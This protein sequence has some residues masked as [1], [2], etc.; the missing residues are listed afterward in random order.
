MLPTWCRWCALFSTRHQK[1][2]SR[3]EI[4]C[5][6]MRPFHPAVDSTDCTM[7]NCTQ[8]CASTITERCSSTITQGCASPNELEPC[9]LLQMTAYSCPAV[10]KENFL[11]LL[12]QN[13]AHPLLSALHAFLLL[14]SYK[15]VVQVIHKYHTDMIQISHKYVAT[16]HCNC[17]DSICQMALIHYCLHCMLF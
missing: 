9:S 13:C 5:N 6:K 15:I 7:Y 1:S 12:V 4:I 3:S 16:M 8:R 11:A 2:L 17:H 14:K 10:S